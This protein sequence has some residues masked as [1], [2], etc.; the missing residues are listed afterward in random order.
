MFNL[1]NLFR[2]SGILEGDA[3]GKDTYKKKYQYFQSLLAGN[4]MALEIITD[5]EGICYGEKPF[6]LETILDRSERLLKVVYDIA[7][8]L[9]ALSKGGYP[10]SSTPW[11][12]SAS[13]FC[14]VSPIGRSRPRRRSCA[15]G[16]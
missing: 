13:P 6:T 16:P 1:F 14:R 9:N 4:N 7:E 11:N 3:P 8:D 2:K 15:L 12:A 5:I 10:G